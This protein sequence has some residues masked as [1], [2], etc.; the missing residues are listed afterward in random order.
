MGIADDLTALRRDFSGCRVATFVD[1]SSGVVLFTS[2][3]ERLPQERL[4]A[5]LDRAAD[6]L[7]GPAGAAGR[8]ILGEP[9]LG[10]IAPEGEGLLMAWRSPGEPDEVV[11][12]QCDAD[13]D[14]PAF[15]ARAAEALARLEA[16]S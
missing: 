4:D 6:L 11:I 5:V 12:C 10:A 15:A 13:I 14:L 16:G 8:A 9:L 2:A 3:A 7:E 1:L